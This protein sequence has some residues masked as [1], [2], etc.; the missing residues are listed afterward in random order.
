MIRAAKAADTMA[1]IGLMQ[2]AKAKSIYRD[3][4]EIDVK[5]ARQ[6][7]ARCAHFSGSRNA[8]GTLYLVSETDGDIRGFFIADF[9][10]VY[11]VG[12]LL[13]A[14]DHQTYMSD[15]ADPWD[16][17]RCIAAFDEWWSTNPKC[18]KGDLSLSNF[19]PDDGATEIVERAYMRRGY[20]RSAF[21]FTRR[22]ER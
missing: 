19:I 7:L 16:F 2:E 11:I 6:F 21:V 5:L 10:N 3:V 9:A 15:D 8:G 1:V 18:I 17:F 20:E 22:I 12:S 14:R 13:E 4:G